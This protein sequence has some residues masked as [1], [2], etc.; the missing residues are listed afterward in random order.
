[1]ILALLHRI[2]N[3]YDT[4]FMALLLKFMLQKLK[5]ET[6]KS[7]QVNAWNSPPGY[8]ENIIITADTNAAIAY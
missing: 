6:I 3:G 5:S 8:P 2:T 7:S 1:M 4:T